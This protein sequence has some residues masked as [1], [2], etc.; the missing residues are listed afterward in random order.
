VRRCA[1]CAPTRNRKTSRKAR[2]GGGGVSV[3]VGVG[4]G[5]VGGGGGGGGVAV[6]SAL[7]PLGRLQPFEV[8]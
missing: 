7:A 4:G 3:G 2:V 8:R 5:G 1:A 6:V